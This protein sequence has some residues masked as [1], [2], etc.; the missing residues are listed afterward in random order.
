[1]QGQVESRSAFRDL[2]FEAEQLPACFL[3]RPV[4]PHSLL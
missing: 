4:T 2:S 1:M 3:V